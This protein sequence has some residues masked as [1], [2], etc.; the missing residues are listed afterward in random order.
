MEITNTSIDC[1]I[2]SLDTERKNDIVKLIN[3]VKEITNK[4]PRLWGSIIGFGRLKYVYNSGHS[5][6][7]PIVGLASRKQAITIYL[8]YDINKFDELNNLGK[9]KTGKGCL[10][11]KKLEDIDIDV[12][13]LL[14]KEAIKDT[15]SLDFIKEIE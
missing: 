11:I 5:G 12:M 2:N 3:L 4:E 1:L 6:E 8:S 7:M 15:L 9:H 13:R 10:Y 14:I